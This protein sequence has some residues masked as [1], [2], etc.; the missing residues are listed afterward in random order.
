MFSRFLGGLYHPF[1]SPRLWSVVAEALAEMAVHEIHLSSRLLPGMISE[2][3]RDDSM[4][5]ELL[6]FTRTSYYEGCGKIT[7]AITK[8]RILSS[9]NV[10]DLSCVITDALSYREISKSHLTPWF[11]TSP[12]KYTT[13]PRPPVE[14][15]PQ[16]PVLIGGSLEGTRPNLPPMKILRTP[17]VENER[18]NKTPKRLKREA[19]VWKSLN[20]PNIIPLL[21][22]IGAWSYFTLVL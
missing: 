3:S 7:G 12:V 4:P 22:E 11:L 14:D 1:Y 5:P 17:R 10:A 13:R 8:G 9:L 21:R 15:I 16:C 18:G 6:K 2:N 20:H 19:R